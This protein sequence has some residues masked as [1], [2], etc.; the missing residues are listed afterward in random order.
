MKSIRLRLTI[1]ALA[2]AL[3]G[4][5]SAYFVSK[6]SA[7]AYTDD[8]KFVHMDGQSLII[9][10]LW[11][12]ANG[13]AKNRRP[14]FSAFT[15]DFFDF[16]GLAYEVRCKDTKFVKRTAIFPE[17]EAPIAD[18][19][20]FYDF[21]DDIDGDPWLILNRE[22]ASAH[23]TVAMASLY[24]LT[25]L[26]FVQT[27]EFVLLLSG[28]L[29]SG[30]LLYFLTGIVLKPIPNL[31]RAAEQNTEDLAGFKS[32]PELADLKTSLLLLK[33]KQNET[34]TSKTNLVDKERHFTANAAHELLTPLS[35]IKTEVQLQQRLVKNEQMKTWL[36]ELLTRVNRATHTVDQLMTL[37]RLDPDDEPGETSELDAAMMISEIVEDYQEKWQG[38]FIEISK[39]FAENN[40]VLAYPALCDTLLRNL[41]S[42]ACKYTPVEG[43]IKIETKAEKDQLTIRIGNSS[44]RLPEYLLD[45]MFERFVRGPHAVETGSGLGLAIAKRIA[46]LHGTTLFPE[47]AK[48]KESISFEFSL[49]LA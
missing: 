14:D 12:A 30:L 8:Y 1:L 32:P 44:E 23:I 45:H 25:F 11:E 49:P 6:K 19:A 3:F 24:E 9:A 16:T 27:R 41:L 21:K 38:K 48:D 5:F 20:D 39:D 28:V 47:I 17:F 10:E 22:T 40:I 15:E 31:A 18:D 2:L 36:G 42:N 43:E 33:T 34:E 29:L 35:A 37:A 13:C 46:E 26:D 4:F 7:D